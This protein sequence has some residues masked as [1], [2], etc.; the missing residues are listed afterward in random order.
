MIYFWF[1]IEK[2]FR[3]LDVQRIATEPESCCFHLINKLIAITVRYRAKTV[4][5]VNKLEEAELDQLFLLFYH[6]IWYSK[7]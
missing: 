5:I 1:L 6:I 2:D 7:E 3:S 4:R